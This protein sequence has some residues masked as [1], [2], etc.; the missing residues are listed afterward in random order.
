MHIS[1]HFKACL[2]CILRNQTGRSV[3]MQLSCSCQRQPT[4]TM[5]QSLHVLCTPLGFS[6]F[7]T[8]CQPPLEACQQMS[9]C[10]FGLP[11]HKAVQQMHRTSSCCCTGFHISSSLQA[12]AHRAWSCSSWN[13]K[14]D[15]ACGII[16]LSWRHCKGHESDSTDMSK[17]SRGLQ[18]IRDEGD[19]E[20]GTMMSLSG[21]CCSWVDRARPRPF[22]PFNRTQG[23]CCAPLTSTRSKQ[24]ST[25]VDN[26]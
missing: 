14:G 21:N 22:V 10:H 15:E 12:W 23:P 3:V 11:L 20:A 25:V 26:N 6:F 9:C 7:L 8:R 18:D 17:S 24:F 13:G 2:S 16:H 1:Q 4:T 19:A 5:M